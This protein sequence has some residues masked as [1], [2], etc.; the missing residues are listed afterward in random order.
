MEL[1]DPVFRRAPQPYPLALRIHT[2][3]LKVM[4]LSFIYLS[5]MLSLRI[6]TMELKAC[7]LSRALFTSASRI[8]TMELKVDA[9]SFSACI[10]IALMNPYNGIERLLGWL[11]R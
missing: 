6:H 4:T 1:K 7:I 11:A 10:P 3:E 8:H 9:M 2:M 5:S